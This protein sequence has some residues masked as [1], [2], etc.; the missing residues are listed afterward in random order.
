M[1]SL[2]ENP[3]VGGLLIGLAM[4]LLAGLE[5]ANVV[6]EW[7]PSWAAQA[8]VRRWC[9]IGTGIAVCVVAGEA[10]ARFAILPRR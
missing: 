3:D 10:I 5:L 9:L 6:P 7:V 2:L 1:R 8:G 4:F